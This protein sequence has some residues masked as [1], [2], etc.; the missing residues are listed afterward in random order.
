MTELT[1]TSFR[2]LTKN[3][4]IP[5]RLQGEPVQSNAITV[6]Y[7]EEI[8]IVKGPFD[9][10]KHSR[11]LEDRNK[12]HRPGGNPR[13]ESLTMLLP[14]SKGNC[15]H[16]EEIAAV[17]VPPSSCRLKRRV[18]FS[19]DVAVLQTLRMVSAPIVIPSPCESDDSE[20]GITDDDDDDDG[21]DRT[22]SGS[23]DEDRSD[24]DPGG[25]SD[26]QYGSEEGNSDGEIDAEGK[27]AL[28]HSTASVKA[29]LQSLQYSGRSP[30]ESKQAR[31]SNSQRLALNDE[32]VRQE[33]VYDGGINQNN[34]SPDLL[35]TQS[36]I[37]RGEILITEESRQEWNI[38][39]DN[40]WRPRRLV[41][42]HRLIE[43]DDDILDY[44]NS[45]T[46][47]SRGDD[48]RGPFRSASGRKLEIQ[49]CDDGH[50]C[51]NRAGSEHVE[52]M[53]RRELSQTSVELG[54]PKW[55]VLHHHGDEQ[56]HSQAQN[57]DYLPEGA[58]RYVVQD[59]ATYMARALDSFSNPS[60]GSFSLARSKS[61]PSRHRFHCVD[62]QIQEDLP[63]KNLGISPAFK[64]TVSPLKRS[65]SQMQS[66]DL[67]ALTRR[68]SPGTTP[69][70]GRIQP[71]SFKPPFLRD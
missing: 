63:A 11:P 56:P 12:I 58:S 18:T 54:N 42:T 67:R 45:T 19:E 68:M 8:E 59:Y 31:A 26:D 52:D 5:Q 22:S 69:V 51:S 48:E 55:S 61:M 70:R 2:D 64:H 24:G 35:L 38:A 36:I 40:S 34:C 39:E 53:Q 17:T 47:L 25:G 20:E 30:E 9:P 29:T 14:P 27:E 62:E 49:S 23:S 60:Q 66:T 57:P 13:L 37:E 41:S 46:E 7:H 16:T 21:D 15:I 3:I 28:Q 44:P 65:L 43:V 6:F 71:L 4:E 33:S 10:L 32:F 1:L 50:A